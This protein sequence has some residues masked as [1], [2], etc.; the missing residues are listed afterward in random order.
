MGQAQHQSN[1][2]EGMETATLG[3]GCFWCLEAVFDELQGVKA[4]EPGYSGGSVPNPSYQ[5]VCTDK[6]GQAE[7]VQVT[8]DPKEISFRDILE[9]FFTF[10]D[11]TTLNRQGADVGARYRSVIFHH[12]PEQKAT[13]EQLIKEL[14]SEKVWPGHIVTQ[15]VPFEAFYMAEDYHQEYYRLNSQQPYCQIVSAPKMAKLRQLYQKR[16]KV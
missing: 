6:T 13:A 5:Q 8:S 16:L 14:E 7:V 10:H 4:V 1:Q 3:G 15:V 9:A 2:Q 11:P 12:S